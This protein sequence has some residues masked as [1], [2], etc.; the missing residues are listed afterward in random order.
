MR[1]VL[2]GGVGGHTQHEL[3]FSWAVTIEPQHIETCGK[4]S[5][6]VSLVIYNQ[7]SLGMGIKDAL[8]CSQKQ[9]QSWLTQSGLWNNISPGV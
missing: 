1:G 3:R 7:S 9:N 5:S 6:S 2:W 4:V 8:L